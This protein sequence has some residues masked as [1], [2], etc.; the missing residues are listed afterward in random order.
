MRSVN[1]L[2]SADC[3][4]SDSQEFWGG[5]ALR[6]AVS[7]S[8]VLRRAGAIVVC[9]VRLQSSRIEVCIGAWCSR[10]RSTYDAFT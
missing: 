7:E 9:A 4:S 2:C 8:K 3:G 10:E 6:L 5:I 1:S